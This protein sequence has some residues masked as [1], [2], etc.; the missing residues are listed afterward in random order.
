MGA[1][2]GFGL[3]FGT[4]EKRPAFEHYWQRLSARPAFLRAKQFDDALVA[5]QKKAAG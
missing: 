4:F 5:E 1:A 2:I 3:M